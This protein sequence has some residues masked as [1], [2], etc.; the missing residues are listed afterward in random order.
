MTQSEEGAHT[1]LEWRLALTEVTTA[2]TAEIAE[3]LLGSFG[4]PSGCPWP[5]HRARDKEP[6]NS[7]LE[8]RHRRK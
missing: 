2:S 8:A 3:E 4:A 6:W 7:L 5:F 1:P